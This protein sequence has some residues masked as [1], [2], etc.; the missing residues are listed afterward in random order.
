MSHGF[1][2]VSGWTGHAVSAAFTGNI[3]EILL[4]LSVCAAFLVLLVC[5]M[6]YTRQDYYEDVLKSSEIMQSAITARKEGR[7]EESVPQNIKVGKTGIGHG[8]GSDTL[9]YKHKL[10][11][12]RARVFI[13]DTVSLI[14]VAITIALAFVMKNAGIA[15]VFIAATSMQ[16]FVVSLGRF[17][18]ELTKPFIYLIP[19]PPLQK[20][21][22]ALAE[23]IP[24][25]LVEALVIF[26]P[27][28]FILG[29]TPVETL[30]CILARLSFALLFTAG[31]IAVERIWGGSASKTVV[32]LLYFAILLLMAAP[33]IVL[34]VVMTSLTV[35]ANEN[36]AILLSLSV[37]N[38]PVSLLVL[39]LCKNMLQYAELNQN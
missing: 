7:V 11:N 36:A 37:V 21:L 15:A 4:G 28:T 19:E 17:N 12:R 29:L 22:Y 27:V 10:E 38:I 31:N 18:K 26:V 33:G 8:W 25:A 32:L 30:L 35:F 6:T 20:I 39:F 14:F 9:Y 24:S 1:F 13:L 2:P 34:A 23:A 3:A 16:I 5:L